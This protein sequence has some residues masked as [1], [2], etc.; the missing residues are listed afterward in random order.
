MNVIKNVKFEALFDL[1]KNCVQLEYRPHQTVVVP[2]PSYSHT[3]YMYNVLKFVVVELM[4]LK[5]N[6]NDF[7]VFTAGI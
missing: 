2:H 4:I 6:N 7:F 5:W 1:G 3:L